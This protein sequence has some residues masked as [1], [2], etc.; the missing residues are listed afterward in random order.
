MSKPTD[1]EL[2]TILDRR[3][4]NI[5]SK[6]VA[7]MALELLELRERHRRFVALQMAMHG[8]WGGLAR[9]LRVWGVGPT[10]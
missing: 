4:S 7:E 10:E 2:E 5:D 3:G 1:E 6:T 9:Q 8:E